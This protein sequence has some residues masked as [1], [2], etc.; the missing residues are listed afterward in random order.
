MSATCDAR[1]SMGSSSGWRDTGSHVTM[2]R[3]DHSA[4]RGHGAIPGPRP[5][6]RF[7][8]HPPHCLCYDEGAYVQADRVP[9]REETDVDFVAVVDQVI[10]LLRQRGRLT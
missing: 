4:E 8:Q 10:A 2:Q 7:F 6:Q 3:E 9:G 5:L 1:A